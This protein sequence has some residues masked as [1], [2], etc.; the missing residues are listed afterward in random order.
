MSALSKVLRDSEGNGLT[1]WCP[2]CDMAHRIQHGAGDGPRWGWNGDVER[3][4]F[5]PSVLVTGTDFTEAG[6]AEYERWVEE[7]CP[8]LEGRRFESRA[9]VCHSFVGCNGAQPGE[10][11]FLGDCT[12]AL[13]GQTVPLAEFPEGWGC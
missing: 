5:T 1:F 3:P 12:H 4:V 8:P 11:I 9:V 7:G 10:I 6:E 2:G 13:A